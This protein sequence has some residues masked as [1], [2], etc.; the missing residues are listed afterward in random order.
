MSEKPLIFLVDDE[1]SLLEVTSIILEGE[2]FN[3]ATANNAKLAINILQNLSPDLIVSDITMPEMSGYEFFQHVRNY[4]HLQNVPFVFM[5]AH[6][7]IENIMK[8]KE[9]GVD[10]YL[11]KPVDVNILL[12]TIRGKLKRRQMLSDAFS[13]QIDQMKNQLFKMISHEMRTPLTAIL[14]ATEILTDGK[15]NLSPTDF[16]TFLKML[17]DGSKRLNS[18]VEDFLLA[19]KIESNQIINEFEAQQLHFNAKL[20]IDRLALDFETI[21]R[22]KNLQFIN[23]VPDETMYVVGY[24]PHLEDILKRLISN[25]VK[26]SDENGK[27]IVKK[28]SSETREIYSIQDFGCGISVEKQE[29]MFQKFYQIDR[30]KQEQQGPGL[31]LYIAQRLAHINKFKLWFESEVGKGSTFY[32]SIPK[33]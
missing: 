2:G 33:Q 31:G 25:A 28:T 29:L 20:I 8:G 24:A 22:R 23:E 12:S 6:S 13:T 7:D 30:D 27:I 1:E 9:L 10:D 21:Q 4:P 18:M 3:T 16:T 19:I 15:E 11:T 32:F 17:Q 5:T 26:F 14:G